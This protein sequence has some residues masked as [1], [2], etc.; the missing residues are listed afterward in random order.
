MKS[1]V[2]YACLCAIL[3]L[4]ASPAVLAEI[5]TDYDGGGDDYG[6]AGGDGW[7]TSCWAV[8]IANSSYPSSGAVYWA[9]VDTYT[10]QGTWCVYTCSWDASAYATYV[11]S[12][13]SGASAS[14]GG[15]GSTPLGGVSASASVSYP[16]PTTDED[17]PPGDSLESEE[18][19]FD[20]YSG[21]SAESS[22]GAYA[23]IGYGT[24]EAGATGDADANVSMSI[25]DP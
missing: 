19:Y 18:N 4:V 14:G 20:A 24:N 13:G 12:N 23:S 9:S 8:A 25:W 15:S 5:L 6:Y 7:G 10:T 21:V 11:D 1:S 17:D 2:W 16:G 3:M 22:C